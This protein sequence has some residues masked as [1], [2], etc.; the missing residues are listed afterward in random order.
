MVT[1]PYDSL[2]FLWEQRALYIGRI[3]TPLSVSTGAA[4]LILALEKPMHFMTLGKSEPVAC[5]SLIVPPG[6]NVVINTNGGHIANCTL[7]PIG[8]DMHSLTSL[9]QY[10]SG[11]MYYQLQNE[12]SCIEFILGLCSPSPGR[13]GLLKS[14][15]QYLNIGVH[16][17][18]DRKVQHKIDL[19]IEQVILSIQN[20]ISENTSVTE[21]ARKVNLSPSR[22]IHLFKKHTGL[23]IR[24]YRLWCRLYVAALIFAQGK[25]LDEAAFETGFSDLPHFS[26]TFRSMVGVAPAHFFSPFL[27][28]QIIIPCRS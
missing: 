13:H 9:A 10:R 15:I 21:L 4:A 22:L 1:T 26:R 3:G 19:R 18:V 25:S 6:A 20:S 7:D 8:R 23:P 24:R 28:L 27:D 5:R 17:Q 2:L 14:F 16:K 12:T 11:Q